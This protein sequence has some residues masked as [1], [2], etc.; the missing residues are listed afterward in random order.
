MKLCFAIPVS[1]LWN[2]CKKENMLLKKQNMELK[3]V[4][5]LLGTSVFHLL[6]RV[7]DKLSY[8]F[9]RKKRYLKKKQKKNRIF[10]LDFTECA[11]K[12]LYLKIIMSYSSRVNKRERSCPAKEKNSINKCI[13]MIY[14]IMCAVQMVNK[15]CVK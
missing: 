15:Q 7:C 9:C 12:I 13:K 14:R 10:I 2:T 8:L 4:L 3:H 6:T 1:Q 11:D 5:L